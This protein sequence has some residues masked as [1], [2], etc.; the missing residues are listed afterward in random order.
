MAASGGI[1][2]W[3]ERGWSQIALIEK[4]ADFVIGQPINVNW[5]TGG[6]PFT[7]HSERFVRYILSR[8]QV[9]FHRVPSYGDY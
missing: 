3:F 4:L 5:V 7:P 8:V 2:I 1:D 9:G 6:V